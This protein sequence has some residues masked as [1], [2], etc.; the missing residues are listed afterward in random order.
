MTSYQTMPYTHIQTS[1]GRPMKTL[2]HRLKYVHSAC[3]MQ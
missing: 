2:E 1:N 3:M